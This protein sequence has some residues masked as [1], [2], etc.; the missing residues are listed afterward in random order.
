M[1]P[2]DDLK[3]KV[4]LVTGS[5][6]GIGKAT[7]RL[8]LSLG[9]KVMLHGRSNR[10]NLELVLEQ[11]DATPEQVGSYLIDFTTEDDAAQKLMGATLERFGRIDCL[12]NNAGIYP[13]N[14]IDTLTEELFQKV[15]RV[16]L[17]TPMFLIQ[18]AAK[19]FRQQPTRGTILNI[20]SIN[21][22]CGQ[23]D[24][25]VYSISKG[26]L[27][28]MTRNLGHS[29]GKEGIRVNQL[30]VGWTLTETETTTREKEGFS[31]DWEQRL[32]ATL[33]P[34]GHLLRPEQVAQQVAFWISE[35]SAPA[36]GIVCDFEQFPM[37][38]RNLI[39]ELT[40][41]AESK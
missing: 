15:M 3:N 36:S 5:S 14:N 37:I 4:V 40:E 35:L 23:K 17:K 32:P 39:P 9:A 22:Y 33:I 1:H 34:S 19:I 26:G 2:F 21:A 38:G 7:A 31:K 29:L 41:L 6:H 18:E 11:L 20:G 27:M 8:C 30:N 16:N 25:L 12:V 13:R 28:T 10:K 24:L